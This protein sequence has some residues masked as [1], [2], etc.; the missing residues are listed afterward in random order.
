MGFPLLCHLWMSFPHPFFLFLRLERHFRPENKE[1]I[2][3]LQMFLQQRWH[4][5]HH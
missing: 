5:R 3:R 4:T 2:L 1:L